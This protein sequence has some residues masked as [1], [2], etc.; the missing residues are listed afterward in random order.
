LRL[1]IE[2]EVTALIEPGTLR[3]PADGIK[4]FGR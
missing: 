4:W 3:E 1:K 2:L